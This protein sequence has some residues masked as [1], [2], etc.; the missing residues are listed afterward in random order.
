MIRELFFKV[1]ENKLIVGFEESLQEHYL[2]EGLDVRRVEDWPIEKINY[3]PKALK[4]K[5]IPPIT[6]IFTSFKF[7]L[8]LKNGLL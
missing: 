4:E 6:N 5:L 1:R 8:D 3:V 2:K 7:N